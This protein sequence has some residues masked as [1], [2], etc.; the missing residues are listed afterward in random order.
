MKNFVTELVYRFNI[1]EDQSRVA[2]MQFSSKENTRVEFNFDDYNYDKDRL[3]TLLA[4]L[5]QSDGGLTYT[6]VA[7]KKAREEVCDGSAH[8]ICPAKS[9]LKTS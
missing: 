2:L 7:L 3:M 1:S 4:N 5:K 8:F 9:D 6:N